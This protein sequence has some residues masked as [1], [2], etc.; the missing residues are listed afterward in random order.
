MNDQK[1][2]ER[3][4]FF[5]AILEKIT[6]DPCRMALI[7]VSL[8]AFVGCAG[9]Q[10]PVTQTQALKDD[11]SAELSLL[12]QDQVGP[13][14]KFNSIQI[15]LDGES[16]FEQKIEE[17]ENPFEKDAV[18]AFRGSFVSGEHHLQVMLVYKSVTFGVFEYLSGYR[19]NMKS[20]HTFSLKPG[21][22]ITMTIRAYEK[23]SGVLGEGLTV[24]FSEE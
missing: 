20:S 13:A 19:F 1:R 5:G 24:S 18:H 6:T 8:V 7:V 11:A 2:V 9:Q 4:K 17:E 23:S 14:Y 12:F 15:E 3:E 10:T 21:K 22:T 16:I